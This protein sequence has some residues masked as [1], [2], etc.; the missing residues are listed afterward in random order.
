MQ[1]Q[2]MSIPCECT[3]IIFVGRCQWMWQVWDRLSKNSGAM[4]HTTL[5]RIVIPLSV[6]PRGQ[7][8]HTSAKCTVLFDATERGRNNVCQSSLLACL[9]NAYEGQHHL[10]IS[11]YGWM[12][13]IIYHFHSWGLHSILWWRQLP[14]QYNIPGN[15]QLWNFL[16]PLFEI[17]SW[18][19]IIALESLSFMQWSFHCVW[20][21]VLGR[22]PVFEFVSTYIIIVQLSSHVLYN[23]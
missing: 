3:I 5:G 9:K 4:I 2:I 11:W 20:Y 18:T 15:R 23:C 21:A 1:F 19:C 22:L 8:I 7:Y 14:F 6:Q 16:W 10:D 17:C 12:N 13:R